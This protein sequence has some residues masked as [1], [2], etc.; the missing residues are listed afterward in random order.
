MF[1]WKQKTD[2]QKMLYTLLRK[3]TKG[4]DKTSNA[5]FRPA[6]FILRAVHLLKTLTQIV[7][8]NYGNNKTTKNRTPASKRNE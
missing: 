8:K 6:H 5:F 2:V 3:A 4:K 7:K 1:V